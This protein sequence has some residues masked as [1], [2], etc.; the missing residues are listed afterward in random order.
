MRI[1][2]TR[3]SRVEVLVLALVSTSF[4]DVTK[5]PAQEGG[6]PVWPN[7]L[8]FQPLRDGSRGR[9]IIKLR[10]YDHIG[11]PSCSR[12]GEW[13]AFDA[14][15]V[16]SG[17]MVSTP[18][19]W[20]VRVDGTGLRKFA[21]GS[22]PRW[23]PDGKRLLFMREG[24]RE[25]DKDLGI[26]MIDRGGTGERR[27]GPGRWPDWSPDGKRI[28]FS[29]GGA[30]GGGAREMARIYVS[31]VDG[32]DRRS[33]CDGD[34]PSWSPDGEKIA[35]C[36]V[37]RAHAAPQIRVVELGTGR[38]VIVGA[39]WFRPV[40]SPDGNT[41]V[42]NGIADQK[43][44]M[45][46]LSVDEPKRKPE[47]LSGGSPR[48]TS[49]CYGGKGDAIIFVQD[50]PRRK[51]G[52]P[53]CTFD[54][55][56][57]IGSI[58]LTVVYFVPK[59]RKPLFDWRE[60]VD[61]FCKRLVLFQ[62]RE[63]GGRS[64]LHIHVH[65]D[66]LI[67]AKSSEEIRG[68]N[69][70]ETFDNSIGAARSQLKWPAKGDGFTILLLLSDINWRELDD[71]H[72][73]IRVDGVP[74]FEG[75]VDSEGRHFPGAPSGGSRAS[76]VADEALGVGLVSGDGWRVPYSGSDCAVYHEGVGHPIGL[77]HPE[78]LDDSVMGAAQYKYWIN[79]TW[80]DRS[81]KQALGWD[82]DGGD[83]I[84]NRAE[85]KPASDLFTAFTALP[86]PTIPKPN[87]PVKLRFTW[88]ERSKLREIRIRV[89]TD[90]SGPWQTVPVSGAGSPP[91]SLPLGSFDRPTPVSYRVDAVLEDGQAA[92]L[93][94][95]FQ[96]GKP[97]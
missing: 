33:V 5:A 30:A 61:Y 84:A 76:Y 25:P 57:E 4:A 12:D 79:Q 92:E 29:I 54:G 50:Q 68:K 23:S 21:E 2:F 48:G 83:G 89:Q 26:F 31:Q 63:S 85:R 43:E 49:P 58:D 13:V 8:R 7:T 46:R 32:S 93:W 71:F 77:P 9:D 53:P 69:A 27:I 82:D 39:G 3:V 16:A 91:A 1:R 88:P 90:L 78:P 18:E 51:S 59:D 37:D 36:L 65:P 86:T 97:E 67:V 72:R 28:A 94:G 34:C 11:S 14:Y 44:G 10:Q 38:N 73:T 70:G 81:Q 42:C 62:R 75:S 80:V 52:D 96:V 19:C 87:E 41:L 66:P 47:A 55:R 60:R 40:W 6:A 95:Y 64:A 20:V 15:K 56:Y 17:E 35:C 74:K 24:Q 45:V 22:V